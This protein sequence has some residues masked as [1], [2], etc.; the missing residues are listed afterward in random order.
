MY[1]PA[2]AAPAP[3]ADADLVQA[4]LGGSSQAF[5][6]LV[7]RYQDRVY[8]L[9][10]R[11]TRD[12]QQAEDVAQET[13]LKA[14]RR[15]HSF[16]FSSSFFTWLYRIALNNASDALARRRRDPALVLDDPDRSWAPRAP[17]ESSDPGRDAMRAELAHVTRRVLAAL[18]AKYRQI[19]VL[20]EYEELSYEEIA[21]VL[22]CALG[23][24]ESRLFRARARFRAKLEELFPDFLPTEGGGGRIERWRR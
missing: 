20:R 8:R 19:L 2:T 7:E 22:D 10:F 16:R 11:V 17:E 4:A 21:S 3:L 12:A 23:T 6:G 14:F 15:L 5:R 13:F 9:A 1:A 24:V 18:P